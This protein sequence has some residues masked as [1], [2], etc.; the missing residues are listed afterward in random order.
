M[1]AP[2]VCLIDR[3]WSVRLSDFGLANIIERWTKE[4]AITHIAREM[5]EGE[6]K[7]IRNCMK[8]FLNDQNLS[9]QIIF[10]AHRSS[11]KIGNRIVV[12]GS[13][14]IGSYKVYFVD[15]SVIYKINIYKSFNFLKMT[16]YK[17]YYTYCGQLSR[18]VIFMH[19]ALSCMKYCSVHYPFQRI[20]MYL[21]CFFAIVFT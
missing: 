19:L 5:K 2:S 21:V 6:E 16:R 10:I 17:N 9:S 1:L 20:W 11:S 18:L 12:V 4:G 14:K 8:F 3:N 13:I 15:R 7:D